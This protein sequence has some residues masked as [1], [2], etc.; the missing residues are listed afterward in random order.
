MKMPQ[1][2]KVLTWVLRHIGR[3]V[4]DVTCLL[5]EK[6]EDNFDNYDPVVYVT[7]IPI[8]AAITVSSVSYLPPE[9]HVRPAVTPIGYP[10]VA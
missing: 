6:S 9:R 5:Q 8:S 2:A 3:M 4:L 7:Y 1:A 10:G